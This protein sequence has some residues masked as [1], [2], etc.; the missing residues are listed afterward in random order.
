[1]ENIKYREMGLRRRRRIGLEWVL[2]K[3]VYNLVLTPCKSG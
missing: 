2:E 1:M 3:E